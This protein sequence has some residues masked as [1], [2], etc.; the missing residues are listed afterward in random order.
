MQNLGVLLMEFFELYGH[1]FNYEKTG[2]SIRDGGT[3][4]DKVTRDWD[5]PRN[6]ALLSIEDPIDISRFYLQP[7]Y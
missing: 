2:I 3:Y 4:F 6:P 5:D 1:Y 7:C